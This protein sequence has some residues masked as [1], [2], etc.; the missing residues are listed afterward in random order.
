M[1]TKTYKMFTCD[2]DF[3][4][5]YEMGYDM[6]VNKEKRPPCIYPVTITVQAPEP[7]IKITPSELIKVLRNRILNQGVDEKM[8][9]DQL[10]GEGWDE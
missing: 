2:D 8:I 1:K 6:L 7:S 4:R 9:L 3:H 5:S 10:F